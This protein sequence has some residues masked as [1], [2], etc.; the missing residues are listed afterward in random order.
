MNDLIGNTYSIGIGHGESALY[1]AT[2]TRKDWSGEEQLVLEMVGQYGPD[3]FYTQQL[4]A[5][6]RRV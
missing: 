6:L 2:S 3:L 4:A 5:K 1:K